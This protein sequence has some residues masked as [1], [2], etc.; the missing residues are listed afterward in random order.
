MNQSV[1]EIDYGA[2]TSRLRAHPDILAWA[3][4]LLSAEDPDTFERVT[5]W[6]NLEHTFLSGH[7]HYL[8]SQLNRWGIPY[9]V[10]NPPLSFV[11]D[12]PDCRI[13][14]TNK[15][16]GFELHQYQ[17]STV[18]KMVAGVRGGVQLATGAGKTACLI[19][20]LRWLELMFQRPF[21]S[22]TVMPTTNLAK[23]MTGR[24][25]DSGL[26]ARTMRGGKWGDASHIVTVINGLSKML[27]AGNPKI[28]SMLQGRDVLCYDEGHHS[29]A[30]MYYEVALNCPA[31][32]RWNLSAT[33]YANQSNPY[34]HV[35]DM[36]I[37]GVTG[38]TLAKIPARF[39]WEHGFVE[40]PEITFIPVD[41]P[42]Y[43][44]QYGF[45]AGGHWNDMSV[46]RGSGRNA[47]ETGVEWDLVVN[48]T[49]RNELIRR[50]T[51]WSL[52]NEPDSKVVILVQRLDH[53]EILQKMLWAAGINSF[54]CY[55]GSKV[56]TIDRHGT[57]KKWT[58]HD[59]VLLSE[60][61]VGERRVM[62]GSQ[63]FDEG[64]SFPLFTDL[65]LA[66]AGRGGE[67]NRRVFQRVGRAMHSGI[68][69]RVR[70][71]YDRTHRMVQNQAEARIMALF[72]E[73][74]PVRVDL[75]RNVLYPIPG[76][77]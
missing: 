40:E 19:A 4:D 49:W 43:S 73:G 70:D 71:F 32:Y 35:G 59:D 13:L 54:C 10:N 25:R 57:S 38:P 15:Q 46:W 45:Y 44:R 75:P 47:S 41:F 65:I 74:Y 23:Q 24:M 34:N 77:S 16:P 55:G 33:L 6:N 2:I 21:Y 60:F 68:K 36:R 51:Y 39:L 3:A 56:V 20:A 63:K 9:H 50:L 67:A 31:Y 42:D 11:E 53:G 5:F 48:S 58:D 62:I 76:I 27:R 8:Q 17:A 28:V 22:L 7:L 72:N 64:Q 29:Q 69:V 52:M 26:N 1:C 14:A 37:M 66:Q 18:R 61:E 12:N 30:Q